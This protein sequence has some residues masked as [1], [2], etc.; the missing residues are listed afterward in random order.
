MQKDF[1]GWNEKIKQIQNRKPAIHFHKRQ[2]WWCSM[3]VNIGNELDGSGIG[4]AR[5]VLIIKVLSDRT[6]L[7]VPL[8]SATN[9]HPLRIEVGIVRGKRSTAIISQ[10]RVID[11][12]R[13]TGRIG[14]VPEEIYKNIQK[15]VKG[16]F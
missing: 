1:D 6:C 9:N 16:L 12:A 3:G 5:P 10:M 2:I 15:N 7:V 13:L 11:T 14:S 4:Y 8:T